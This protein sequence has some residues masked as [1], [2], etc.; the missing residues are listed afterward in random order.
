MAFNPSSF[1]STQ[2]AGPKPKVIVGDTGSTTTGGFVV[3]TTVTEGF[4]AQTHFLFVADGTTT[5]AQ[6]MDTSTVNIR[7]D[8]A[9]AADVGTMQ[10]SV[11]TGPG[12]W[13]AFT[14]IGTT[15]TAGVTS[16]VNGDFSFTD[17][18]AL[19]PIVGTGVY[20]IS[21]RLPVVTDAI[22]ENGEHV[23]FKF[24]QSSATKFTDSFYVEAKVD[25][26]D[27]VNNLSNTS[28]TASLSGTAAADSF[29]VNALST[30]WKGAYQPNGLAVVPAAANFQTIGAY[31][32]AGAGFTVTAGT[33]LST[34]DKITVDMITDSLLSMVNFG[35]MSPVGI[36]TEAQLINGLRALNTID[37]N[38][39]G[40]YM[41]QVTEDMDTGAGVNNVTSTYIIFDSN[42]NGKL[43]TDGAVVPT[44]ATAGTFTAPADDVFVKLLGVTAGSIQSTHFNLV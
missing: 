8:G 35:S 19:D 30:V 31:S 16:N 1:T 44:G 4:S 33:T 18:D 25:I 38:V 13:S 42:G 40:L 2:N 14:N 29:N 21:V 27:A 7:W 12:V 20:G 41:M 9:S 10:Y 28:T 22:A 3:G 26:V 23:L 5:P 36:T 11:M 37:C 17:Q 34:G 43:D 24:T 39:G 15:N 6:L 32:V